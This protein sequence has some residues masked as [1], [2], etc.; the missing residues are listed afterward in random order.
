MSTYPQDTATRPKPYS[1]RRTSAR[2]LRI[3]GI[4]LIVVGLIG[5]ALT[6]G[7]PAHLPVVSLAIIGAIVWAVGHI[8]ESL[9]HPAR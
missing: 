1:D 8:R 5:G 3:D 6:Y 4:I 9:E 2:M 7:A